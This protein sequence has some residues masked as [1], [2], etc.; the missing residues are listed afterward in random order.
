VPAQVIHHAGVLEPNWCQYMQW[1][2]HLQVHLHLESCCARHQQRFSARHPKNSM[3]CQARDQIRP[4]VCL[5][6]LTMVQ[7]LT[8][9]A[10]PPM[11]T[12]LTV[13]I[14]SFSAS[15]GHPQVHAAII[16]VKGMP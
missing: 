13:S 8:A 14:A 10:M 5:C 12:G 3:Q 16:G 4:E 11:A 6:F 15:A 1:H 7:Y 9:F 2:Q